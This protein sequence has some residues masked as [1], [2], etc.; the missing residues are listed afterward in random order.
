[1]KIY[2]GRSTSYSDQVGTINGDKIYRG[3]ST[4]YSDQIGTIEG[5]YATAAAGGAF[6]LLL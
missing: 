2:K 6:L 5:G 4:S 3:R 1:M